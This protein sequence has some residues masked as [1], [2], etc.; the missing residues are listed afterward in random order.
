MQNRMVSVV[1]TSTLLLVGCTSEQSKIA[2]T[3]SERI[4]SPKGELVI[5]PQF[6][7]VSG[8]AEGMSQYSTRPSDA[9]IFTGGGSTGKPLQLDSSRGLAGYVST[10]GK[11][12]PPIYFSAYDYGESVSSVATEED[13]F[14][15]IDKNGTWLVPPK[16]YWLDT[17]SNGLANFALEKDGKYGY[18]NKKGEIVIAPKYERAYSFSGERALV[19][20]GSK[21]YDAST[22]GY[23][24][25]AGNQITEFIYSGTSHSFSEGLAMVCSGKNDQKKCGYIDKSGKI[26]RELLNE[27]YQSQYGDW[28]SML[29]SFSNGLALY[30]G[31][32]FDSIQKW[33]FINK[34]FELQIPVIITEEIGSKFNSQPYDFTGEVQWQTLGTTK[35]FPGKSAAINKNGDIKFYSN[36]EEIRWFSQGISAVKVNGKWG[37]INE[38]NEMVVEPTYDEVREYNEGFAAVRINGLWGFIN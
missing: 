13:K 17:F 28:N 37:F 26:V 24:D 25:L 12:F 6:E 29:G 3:K 38:K 7:S 8:F 33:G 22:C 20:E 27:I 35:D 9:P 14:G 2:E 15:V 19:C 16:F 5:P 32:W 1:L 36:Y 11:I 31:R 21:D 30:G 10:S 18:V 34:K 23:I 4:Y